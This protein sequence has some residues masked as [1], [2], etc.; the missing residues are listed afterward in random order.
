MPKVDSYV[1]PNNCVLIG[2]SFNYVQALTSSESVVCNLGIG[3]FVFL[4]A[5]FA[6]LL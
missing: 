4:L 6:Q 1:A 3:M 5:T 2:G